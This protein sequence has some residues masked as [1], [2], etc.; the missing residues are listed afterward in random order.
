MSDGKRDIA[1]LVV[2]DSR[3]DRRLFK[4]LLDEIQDRQWNVTEAESG[5][6][7]LKLCHEEQ[8]DCVLLDYRLPDQ[9]GLEF[10]TNL[11]SGVC[12]LPVPVVM[13]TGRGDDSIAT[14]ALRR[15]AQ[16]Y[17]VKG[18]VDSELLSRTI[19]YSIERHSL[20]TALEE[21]RQ[22]EQEE[23]EL[24]ALE[25]FSRSGSTGVTAEL[26]GLGPL[27]ETLLDVFEDLVGEYARILEL[28]ME[29]HGFKTQH[30]TEQQLRTLSEQLGV[31]RAEPQDIVDIHTAALRRKRAGANA[32]KAGAY[33]EEGRLLVLKLMG[34]LAAFYRDHT[35]RTTN[36]RE[37]QPVGIG[38]NVPETKETDHG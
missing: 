16:D 5:A 21:I 19:R 9:N 33:A 4:Y 23:R 7:G 24:G 15:G 28:S 38:T 34:L 8:F 29:E 12:Q 17:I 36:K 30:G 10:M 13:I 14:E 27:R 32:R 11:G 37:R 26:F 1:I 22:R 35:G 25:R 18:S 3:E 20:L 2:D 6:E 31:L